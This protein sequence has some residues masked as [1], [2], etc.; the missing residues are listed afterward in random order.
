MEQ[1]DAAGAFE[2][3][4]DRMAGL[5]A[6]ADVPPP[7][8]AGRIPA[9]VSLLLRPA[10]A[11][12]GEVLVIRRAEREGDPW[13]GHLAFPGG[14]ADSLDTSLV[15]TAVRE[16]L[17][18]VGIDV[19]RGGRVLGRLPT[20]RPKNTSL[21]PVDITPFVMRAP[22]GSDARPRR[23]EVEEAFWVSL[24][25][26]R[27]SGPTEVVRMTVDGAPREWRAYATPGGLIWGLT[28]WILTSLLDLAA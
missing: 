2:A 9:A 22:P 12:P 8:D 1:P 16:T 4:L 20:V 11:G 5:L 15:S 6:P 10:P 21:P 26:L 14:R 13:S 3:L 24:A 7:A 19:L 17:E 25:A 18:E 23:G 27:R 28:E